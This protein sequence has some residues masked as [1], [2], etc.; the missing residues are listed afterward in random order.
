MLG[1]DASEWLV[2]GDLHG[3]ACSSDDVQ[4]LPT[5]SGKDEK[6]QKIG[7][8]AVGH[9]NHRSRKAMRPARV[10]ETAS[11]LAIRLAKPG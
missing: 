7:V 9:E 3:R 8:V 6:V 2:A 5:R 10:P 4:T 1:T 11:N